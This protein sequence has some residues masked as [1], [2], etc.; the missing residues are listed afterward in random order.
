MHLGKGYVHDVSLWANRLC[1]KR[2]IDRLENSFFFSFFFSVC[3]PFHLDLTRKTVKGQTEGEIAGVGPSK[4]RAKPVAVSKNR[5]ARKAISSQERTR[6]HA[7]TRHERHFDL[8]SMVIA[9]VAFAFAVCLLEADGRGQAPGEKKMRTGRTG[10]PARLVHLIP[11]SPSKTVAG[12][13]AI[14]EK[15]GVVTALIMIPN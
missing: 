4:R 12:R 7:Y 13:L 10:R 14:Q 11:S 3:S 1:R 9:R 8:G 5:F 15:I 2:L 6:A